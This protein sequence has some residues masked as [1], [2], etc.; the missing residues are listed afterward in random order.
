[1]ANAQKQFIE[2]INLINAG[3]CDDACVSLLEKIKQDCIIHNKTIENKKM[4]IDEI[5]LM[6]KQAIQQGM[7]WND[8]MTPEEAD[9]IFNNYNDTYNFHC[10]WG[11]KSLNLL[12][13]IETKHIWY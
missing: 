8:N 4:V 5:N 7:E 1:M 3:K 13:L 2:M 9:D 12:N 10:E 11:N 6:N